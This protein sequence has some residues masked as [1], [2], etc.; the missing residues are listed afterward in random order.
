M[1]L[2]SRGLKG[3]EMTSNQLTS[4]PP[5][6]HGNSAGKTPTLV[7]TGKTPTLVRSFMIMAAST[8]A[9]L[10]FQTLLAFSFVF[11]EEGSGANVVGPHN[12]LSD[13]TNRRAI[14]DKQTET[15]VVS[16]IPAFESESGEILFNP[17]EFRVG[18]KKKYINR[19]IHCPKCNKQVE[20]A[21][22]REIPK[23]IGLDNEAQ[24]RGNDVVV[25]F[26]TVTFMYKKHF[27]R[28]IESLRYSGYD[29]HIILGV[30]QDIP[31]ASMTYLKENN[32]TVYKAES[33][34]CQKP[35]SNV[36]L[37]KKQLKC[38]KSLETFPVEWGRYE[39]ARQWINACQSC[40]GR[41]LLA[42]DGTD[43]IFQSNPFDFMEGRKEDI[44]FTEEMAAHT[45]PF[46]YD[47]NKE[48]VRHARLDV[49]RFK[50]IIDVFYGP[51]TAD[52]LGPKNRPLLVPST[53]IG[54]RNGILRYLSIMVAELNKHVAASGKSGYP[55]SND[56][57]VMNFLYYSGAFGFPETI[58][59][60]PWGTG[61]FQ[62]LGK[63]CV[64]LFVEKGKNP[65]SQLDIVKFDFNRTG[66]VVNR[67]ESVEGGSRVAPVIHRFQ[68]YCDKWIKAFISLHGELIGEPLYKKPD[69]YLEILKH[70]IESSVVERGQI[71]G[72]EEKNPMK[73]SYQRS[74]VVQQAPWFPAE[75]KCKNTCCAQAIAIL[76]EPDENHLITS[77][78]GLDLADVSVLGHKRKD[79][80]QFSI[81]SL[82][83]DII[84]W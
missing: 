20:E 10:F 77:A 27:G 46:Y 7:R 6:R 48:N 13:F 24:N 37:P 32:V 59:T 54:S 31:E 81:S 14:E 83:F 44:L 76:L 41:V 42:L 51:S 15:P 3:H 22:K 74:T 84:P 25:S 35:T 28:L 69:D 78:D 5:R 40:T 73:T 9:V 50:K 49:G 68:P 33:G 1:K 72:S 17:E 36:K 79:Y 8:F 30:H 53:V 16:P 12:A 34:P 26:V 56:A 11:Y 57:G 61:V 60:L 63:P 18:D 65:N 52:S 43:T 23:P 80:L 66:Y 58:S 29:G 82:N 55:K 2:S 47:P 19:P 67:Y 75:V 38:Y 4:P 70:T 62:N 71:E 64:N 45:N 21:V 39:L